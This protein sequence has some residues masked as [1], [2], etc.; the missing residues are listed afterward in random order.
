[1]SM[2]EV[3]NALKLSPRETKVLHYLRKY[4]QG[5]SLEIQHETSLQQPEVSTAVK[6]LIKRGYIKS[7]LIT[8]STKPVK[9]IKIYSL[10]EDVYMLMI[11]ELKTQVDE[12]L[13]KSEINV[14]L[15]EELEAMIK[16]NT[17]ED[18]TT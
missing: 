9:Q 18:V 1:M 5:T 10:T 4:K 14:A 3:F 7:E 12:L 13:T 17:K 2:N 15:I 16:L 8:P 11:K 6:T